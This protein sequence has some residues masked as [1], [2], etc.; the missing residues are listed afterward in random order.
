MQVLASSLESWQERKPSS[1]R[2]L[3]GRRSRFNNSPRSHRSSSNSPTFRSSPLTASAAAASSSSNYAAAASSSAAA[4]SNSQAMTAPS[5]NTLTNDEYP[6]SV[7]ELVMNGFE[8][9]KVLHAYSLIGDNFDDLLSF[10][11]SSAT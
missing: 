11:L 5:N 9:S 6:A 7:Q 4:A 10:L 2:G 3:D 8:L 1:R